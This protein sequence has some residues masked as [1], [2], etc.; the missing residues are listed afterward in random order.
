M[1]SSL[2]DILEAVK[3]TIG[4]AGL[5]VYDHQSDVTNTPAC[6]ILPADID[7]TG[8]MSMGGDT[9][10]FDLAVLVANV[11][12]RDAQRKL[13][14]YVTGKGEKS[15]REHL[16]RNGNLGLDDVDCVVKGVRGYGG[17]FETATVNYVGAVLKL[18]VTVL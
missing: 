11:N 8:A 3:R 12:T 13:N 9:Y 16:F 18:C 5:N 14:A 7:F 2:Q 1:S 4:Q 6:V 17:N 15:I 10:N